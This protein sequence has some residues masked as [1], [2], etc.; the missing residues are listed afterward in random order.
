MKIKLLIVGV[1]LFFFGYLIYEFV[2]IDRE[3]DMLRYKNPKMTALMKQRM[4]EAK[5]KN[6]AYKINQ[7]WIPIS[8]VSPY[9][10]EAVIVSEDASF[11]DHQGI[12]WYEVKESIKKNFQQGRIARGASTITMQVAKNLF[13]STSRNPF[14]K[15]TEVVIALRMEQKLSKRRILE[16]YLNI[17]ELGN[18]IFGVEYASRVYFGKSASDLTMEESARLA[19]II[20]SPLKYTPNSNKKFVNWRTKLI[21]N[22]MLARAKIREGATNESGTIE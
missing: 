14:R 1:V 19:S 10:I 15:L 9:L 22:R 8:K 3:I 5:R 4:D 17:I 20:P 11:F 6:K 18:G 12:D 21:L 2:R 13:L 16:I 7:I